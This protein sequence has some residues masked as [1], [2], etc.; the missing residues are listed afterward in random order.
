M[1]ATQSYANPI[2][3]ALD[4]IIRINRDM[5]RALEGEIGLSDNE[6]RMLVDMYYQ[7]QKSRIG[8]NNRVKGLD[9]EAKKEDIKAEPH[10]VL[11]WMLKQSEVLEAQI[12]RALATYV[13][14]HPMSWF[15]EQTVGIGAILSAGLL[16]HIDID[17][18]P[19]VGHIWRFAGLDPTLVWGKGQKK[20]FNGQ[21]KTLCWKISDSFVKV[22]GREDAFYGKVYRER[23]QYEIARNDR[24]ELADQAAAKLEKFKIGKGTDA[25]KAYSI[26]RLPPAHIDARARRYAVKLFLSHLHEC[27]WKETHDG[28]LPPKPF[29]IAIAGHAHYIPPPQVKP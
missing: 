18:A 27:W 21:L 24:G 17:K 19:T 22:S 3:E 14:A 6:A 10:E 1:E 28:E 5:L 26:G 16:A 9:R 13:A 2:I 11:S 23:K 20:P 7:W 25:Y 29:A 8:T 15:F 4:P 12:P